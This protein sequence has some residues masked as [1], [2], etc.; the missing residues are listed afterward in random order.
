VADVDPARCPL[1]GQ[2]TAC[3]I[4][5]GATR[6]EDCWCGA[7]CIAPATLAAIPPAA[8]E[9]ACVC[10][11]CATTPDPLVGCGDADGTAVATTDPGGRPAVRLTAACG[12]AL[13]AQLGAQVLSWRD[14]TGDVL[15]I[16][17]A[18]AYAA[19]KAVRGGA[20]IVFPWFGAHPDDPTKPQHG[21]ARTLMWRVASL[22]PG[23]RARFVA[24]DDEATQALWPHRF[25]LAFDVA[26]AD[27]LELA[28]T[29]V[30]RGDAPLRYEEALH[31]YFA[32]GDV[33]TASVHG[34][35]AADCVE[36]AKAPDP[37]ADL[38]APVRFRA[39]TDRV[40]QDAPARI[41][42]RAPALGRV[43]ALVAPEARSAIV[44]SP[45]PAKASTLSGLGPDD[46]LRFCCV[47]TANVKQAARTLAPGARAT[48]RL[49]LSARA[50]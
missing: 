29:V 44:W 23:A 43:V 14:R 30:N 19:G 35:E 46:W 4:A 36:H 47:E 7:V 34:L 24:D 49:T 27:R 45:W 18:E 16:G 39:E 33:T 41:E 6:C 10:R 8:V 42:L 37:H 40:Y 38:R 11:A 48:L 31:T 22:G 2:P 1:C 50:G 20:P 17:S 13:V 32:L 25:H 9:R 12:E 26:L 21:F 15:W 3:A 28:L 5:A